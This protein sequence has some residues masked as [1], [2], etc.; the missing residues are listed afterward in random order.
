MNTQP[1]QE[2]LTE[3]RQHF[4]FFDDDKNG[5]IEL[6][7][8]TQLLKVIEPTST[9]EQAEKGFQIIDDDHNGVIDFDEFFS[10][11]QTCWWQY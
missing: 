1:N 11:W 7:E 9:N 2:K 5:L 6:S 10:W 8:F 4:D 3:I